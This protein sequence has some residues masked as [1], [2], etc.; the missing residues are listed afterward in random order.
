MLMQALDISTTR[1][2]EDLC[3]NTIYASLL[4]GKLSPHTQTFQV[5][6]CTS[7]DLSLVNPDYE[8]MITALTQWSKQCDLVLG[9]ITERIRDVRA[10]A[11]AT[12]R[13]DEKYEQDVENVKHQ[14]AGAKKSLK[15]RSRASAALSSNFGNVSTHHDTLE[16]EMDTEL[17]QDIETGET[18]SPHMRTSVAGGE[19]PTGRKRKLVHTPHIAPSYS[20]V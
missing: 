10:S 20:S 6:S 13:A 8:G 3:I 7:R 14:M 5:T 15:S 17:M 12:K 16:W 4:T 11:A 2:L 19:S 18:I 9:E 1:E